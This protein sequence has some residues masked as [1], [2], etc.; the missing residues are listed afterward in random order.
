MGA[1]FFV[2]PLAF[3]PARL[4]TSLTRP[5]ENIVRFFAQS[6]PRPRQPWTVE[7]KLLLLELAA[8][9]LPHNEIHAQFPGRTLKSIR[10]KYQFLDHKAWTQED[11]QRLSELRS[12]GLSLDDIRSHFPGRTLPGLEV[13]QPRKHV[14]WSKEDVQRLVK[15]R[16]KQMSLHE[17]SCHFTERTLDAL[18]IQI[19]KSVPR[20]EHGRVKNPMKGISLD[21]RR[22]IVDMRARG[23]TWDQISEKFPH[24]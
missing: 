6:A 14:R 19:S 21:E 24:P 10:C 15:M 1:G 11:A 12:K 16:N 18:S 20:D 17:I 9:K 7:D 2:R 13:K 5:R 3:R 23:A 22:K 8:E 4:P